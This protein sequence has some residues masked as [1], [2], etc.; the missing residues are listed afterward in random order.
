MR[1]LMIAALTFAAAATVTCGPASI[2]PHAAMG[3]SATVV[4][5]IDQPRVRG[6]T[7]SRTGLEQACRADGSRQ[8][9]I[10]VRYVQRGRE[11]P[12]TTGDNGFNG[13]LLERYGNRAPGTTLVVCADEPLPPDWVQVESDADLTCEGARVATGEPTTRAIRRFR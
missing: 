10:A 4:P 12:R 5:D 2:R 7:D 3:D 1:F 9:W 13:A 8:G 6:A 11:C